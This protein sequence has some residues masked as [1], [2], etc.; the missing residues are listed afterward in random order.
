[1]ETER[2]KQFCTIIESGSLSKA[3][4]LL[5]ISVSGLSKSMTKLQDDLGFSLFIQK[6]RGVIPTDRGE[7]V[8]KQSFYL[9]EKISS[10]YQI[11]KEVD[12]TIRVGGLEVFTYSLLGK[13]LIKGFPDS[14]ISI[15]ELSPGDLEKAL[16]SKT[17]DVGVT[18]FPIP[19]DGIEYLKIKKIELKVFVKNNSKKF[20]DYKF[21]LPL[22]ANSPEV[23]DHFDQDGWPELKFPRKYLIKTNKLSVGLSLFESEEDLALFIPHFLAND[24]KEKYDL[25]PISLPKKMERIYRDIFIAKRANDTERRIHKITGKIIRN[26]C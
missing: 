7:E 2:L 18:Y 6:G 4:E 24:L 8:Y 22:S 9:L 21:I 13:H 20:G 1:M 25:Y 3:S 19:Q 12:E 16:L 15:L 11:G 26:Y 10:L 5:A 17:I 23:T 14:K